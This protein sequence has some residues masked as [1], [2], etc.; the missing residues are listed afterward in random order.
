ML[1]ARR[2]GQIARGLDAD[3]VSIAQ[4]G[5]RWW[6]SSVRAVLLRSD[7]PSSA[8]PAALPLPTG[9]MIIS[10]SFVG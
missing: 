1:P 4:G 5:R 3:H 8:E 9:P 2:L 10:F 7:P 6:R